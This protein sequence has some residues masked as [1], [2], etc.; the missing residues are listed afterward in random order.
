MLEAAPELRRPAEPTAR[1]T[2]PVEVRAT[3]N[4]HTG[5]RHRDRARRGARPPAVRARRARRRG[6]RARRC[7]RCSARNPAAISCRTSSIASSPSRARCAR[8]TACGCGASGRAG[9][10]ERELVERFF[11][12]IEQVLAGLVSLERRRLRPAGAALPRAE[13]GVQAPRYWETGDE[14][15]AFRYNNYLGRFHWRHIDLMDVLSGFQ[16]RARA[17]L[18]D[19]AGLLGFPA[20]SASRRAGLGC[21]PRRRDRAHPPL[22]RNGRAQHLS[23]LPALRAHARPAHRRRRSPRRSRARARW[24]AER[25]AS[26]TS[27][28]SSRAWDAGRD[29]AVTRAG[30]TR[31]S[32]PAW[33]PRSRTRAR[34]SCARARRSSSRAR[35]P[36]SASASAARSFHKSHDEAEL[37]EV[38]EASPRPR[39]A[40]L[41]ALRRLRRLRAAAPRA[42]R[43]DR[44]QA[45]ASSRTNLDAHRQ[46]RAGAVAAAVARPALELPPPRAPRRRATSR[47]RAGAWS[48]FASS[49]ASTSPALE[50]CEVLAEPVGALVGTLAR[51][52]DV[53]WSGASSIPQIEVACR[54]ATWRW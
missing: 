37:L 34:A 30:R 14:D 11:D 50:R 48:A 18:S 27:P 38:L 54:T 12:G 9:A 53:A 25:Q 7:S 26:R 2:R 3:R 32:K 22:L 20:S 41:R 39:D 4:E 21:L 15:T 46:R 35:C 51:P 33:S 45:D 16:A 36:A 42:R 43:A 49:R 5:L 47:R 13:A 28:N 6:G 23:H 40:A 1:G 24:L 29:Q 8:A 31:R 52:A 10:T 19:M 17:S 44:G